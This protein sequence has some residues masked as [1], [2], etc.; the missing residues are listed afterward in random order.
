MH[1]TAPIGLRL[2]L[3]VGCVLW[4]NPAVAD[5]EPEPQQLPGYQAIAQLVA[6]HLPETTVDHHISIMTPEA[7]LNSLASC[8]TI[9]AQ[10][11]RQPQR[12]AGRTMV[13][14]RCTVAAK[15]QSVYVQIDVIATGA[16]LVAARDLPVNH[17][18]RRED[19]TTEQGDLSQLPRHAL[20]ATSSAITSVLGQQLR[21]SLSQ[22]S[23]LRENLLTRPNV[24]NFG[25]ELII[26]ANGEGFQITRIGEA[27]DTGAIGDIIRVRLNNKQLLRVEITAAGRARPAQ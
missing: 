18:L 22:H 7:A 2:L 6:D 1:N 4:G 16:Y 25:D 11:T 9:E 26:E 27:M 14:L 15:R 13:E 12:L 3:V 10:F 23:V 24:V 8:A 17:T 5:V 20:L 19:I 21:R